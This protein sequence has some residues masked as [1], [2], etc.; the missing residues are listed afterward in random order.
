MGVPE[1][2]GRADQLQLDCLA[3]ERQEQGT[4]GNQW[5]TEEAARYSRADPENI[6]EEAEVFSH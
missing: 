1:P 2:D 6:H 3:D 5:T 4:T